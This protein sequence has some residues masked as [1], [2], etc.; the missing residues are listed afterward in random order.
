[1]QKHHVNV[2]KWIELATP[3]SPK[4]DQGKWDFGGTV[5]ASGSRGSV[6]NIL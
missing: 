1:M 6:E 5:S 3:V 2:T 4:G